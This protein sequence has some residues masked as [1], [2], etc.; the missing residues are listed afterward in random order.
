MNRILHLA[1]VV[2]ILGLLRGA[3]CETWYV[4]SSVSVSGDGGSWETAFKTIQEGIDA[5]QDW[6][7]VIVRYGTYAENIRFN[8]KNIFL[9]STDPEDP[10]V[11]AQTIIDGNRA[12]SVVTFSGSETGACVLSGFTIRN[13][14]AEFGGGVYS[15]TIESEYTQATIRNNVISGNSAK[16]G[17]GL[18]HCDGTIE[19]NT[20]IGNSATWGDGG[21]LLYCGGTIKANIICDNYTRMQGGGLANCDGRIESNRIVRNISEWQGGGLAF[22][23]GAI[24]NN[25]VAGNSAVWAGG[26]FCGCHGAIVNNTI[27]AN[28]AEYGGGLYNCG[29]TIRNCII[30]GNLAPEGPELLSSFT[31]DYSCIRN[32]TGAGAG[33][34]SACPYFVD[35]SREDYHLRGLSP[36][37]DVGDPISDFANEPQPN[38]GRINMG[39]YGNTAEAASASGDADGD[40]LPDEWETLFFANLNQKGFHDPD[41]DGRS[42][43]Q[44]Y[45]D[46]TNPTWSGTWH[47]DG[48]IAV[49]GDGSS[50]GKAFRTIQEGIDAAWEGEAVLVAP[51]VYIENIHVK[52]KNIVLR[53]TDPL[54]PAIVAATVIDGG[55]KTSVVT[56][57]GS[58][59]ERCVLSGFTIRNGAALSVQPRGR[60]GGIQGGYEGHRT[61][62]IIE[63]NVITNNVAWD[64]GG[65][66][67]CGGIIR[68][69][70]LTSNSAKDDGGGIHRCSGV[71]V[72]NRII[73]NQAGDHGGG[74]AKS[75]AAIRNNVICRNSA[76][77]QGGGLRGC[78]GV[79]ENNTIAGNIALYG[80]Q[81]ARCNGSIRN[82][83]FWGASRHGVQLWECSMPIYSC[84]D[85]W[86]RGG[87]GNI[88]SCP[89]FVDEAKGDYHLQS[90]SPC[91]DAGDPI[92]VFSHEP[93]PNGGRVNMGA[94]G[95]T[96]EAESK[97]ADA[98]SDGLPDYWEVTVFGNLDESGTGDADGD[99]M[100]NE[101]E[102]KKGLNPL[103]PTTDWY[104]RA[105]IRTSGDGKLEG[106][107]FKTIQEAIDASSDG[108]TIIVSPGIYPENVKFNGK[109]VILRS[110]DPENP[111]IVASTIIDGGQLGSVVAFLGSEDETCLLAG[112]TIRNGKAYY[113]GGIC[114]GTED[115]GTRATIKNNVIVGNSA[116]RYWDTQR[117]NWVGGFGGGLAFCHG[118]VA[119]NTVSLNSAKLDGGGMYACNATIRNNTVIRNS[120][121]EGS[122]GGLCDCDGTM[123][124]NLICDN[125]AL[126]HGGGL[127]GC[128]GAI[129]NNTVVS[130]TAGNKGGGLNGCEGTIRNCIIWGNTGRVN[131]QMNESS[132][133][134]FCC[135]QDWTE[136][137]EGNIP[138]DPRFVD[139]VS[140]D[141]HLQ[142][143][144]PCVDAGRNFY[145]FAWPQRD[146]DGK[147]RLAGLR[148]DMGCYEWG[149]TP[150]QDG[151]LL[152][153]SDE[154]LQQTGVSV[155]DTDADGLRDGLEML[156]GS[157]PVAATPPGVV[158]VPGNYS[159]IQEALCLAV[160]GD[161]IVVSPGTYYGN[162]Q[163]CGTDVVMRSLDPGNPDLVGQ[164][165][166]DGEGVVPVVSFAGT[167]S[168]ACVLR[169]FTIANGQSDHGAGVRGGNPE[170]HTRATIQANVIMGNE[171]SKAGGGLAWCDGMIE[172][173]TI[174][175]NKAR[176]TGGGL[177]HC[178]GTIQSNIITRN[179]SWTGGIHACNG[180][181]LDNTIS[182]NE[183]NG[184]L[185]CHG[186]I[187][188]NIISHNHRGL[189]DCDG[190]VRCNTIA[191]NRGG[192]MIDC[193]G[194]ILSN[195]IALNYTS[196]GGGLNACDGNIVNNTIVWNGAT[197]VAGG[198]F[199][200][201]GTILN[202]VI[203]GNSASGERQL[204]LSSLPENCC[205]EGWTAGGSGNISDDPAFADP[206]GPDNNPTTIEDNDYSLTPGSACVD[207]GQNEEWMSGATDRLGNARIAAGAWAWRVDMGAN[208]F[209]SPT[210][211]AF[212]GVVADGI[213]LIWASQPGASYVIH[214]CADLSSGQWVEEATVPSQGAVT[215]W[216]DSTPSIRKFYKV[217]VK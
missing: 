118:L 71:I 143:S 106:T 124:N 83:I 175:D 94:Y 74:I 103:V 62:A 100:S 138:D 157:D 135:I 125:E 16:S 79:I 6:D 26:G 130:N 101:E 131:F 117:Q 3:S 60:G 30:W 178:H 1:G 37:I 49:P 111:A 164:T 174:S 84:I 149:A 93:E 186:L 50:W 158:Q 134:S 104:V 43:L 80:D 17:G 75:D 4:D 137:R 116:I 126:N 8:G 159:T 121:A 217:G 190:T 38:G 139:V 153:D 145:W 113:G 51:A 2:L 20:I 13:G 9:E 23:G 161:E 192:G 76:G 53:G 40:L 19:N 177:S 144:S 120:A 45:G 206:D 109:N 67:Y 22:C 201:K 47:V 203:W 42:N 105:S 205:I 140:G 41:G 115:G 169:G 54:D 44:E 184:L 150:D 81:L 165:V 25:V 95:N 59:T 156:R 31:P 110:I 198:L 183:G 11:V 127:S 202:C 28:S 33:N 18:A 188:N 197:Y 46:A 24:W 199:E 191:G 212:I 146:L 195:V 128:D 21:G 114:G 73:G 154:A 29:A 97:C 209:I 182:A 65:I 88:S 91:I 12:G 185:S 142:A 78:E 69:N 70:L 141:Y 58:E 151:D 200:C 213:Q 68:S 122:G 85:R 166:L 89:Y 216:E 87:P 63:N 82:C 55:G 35:A 148:T 179:S 61:H 7:A 189:W 176:E 96:P 66:V 187:E 152:S 210:F 208:E 180:S 168:E 64:G 27:T 92:C 15:E 155:A 167:E 196:R 132:A 72:G 90:W 5:S 10:N 14:Q 123:E 214:S 39:A 119:D 147:C 48:T 57:V 36:C 136:G 207:T 133:P 193:D 129:Q 170:C 86:K 215:T 112:F 181:I 34:I 102:Y 32:W 108:D 99:R 56:L 173:N 211:R 77:D 194:D 52:G 160:P 107:P 171:V 172:G 163:F 98:D 162:F 204:S